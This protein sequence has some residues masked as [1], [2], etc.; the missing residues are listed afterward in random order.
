MIASNTPKSSPLLVHVF[1]A[2]LQ[3]CHQ[4]VKAAMRDVRKT[5]QVLSEVLEFIS[6][7]KASFSVVIT[8]KVQPDLSPFMKLQGAER[9]NTSEKRKRL[10]QKGDILGRKCLV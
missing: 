5:Y 8:Q 9:D 6:G 4:L 1:K 3:L 7:Y 10:K 2:P